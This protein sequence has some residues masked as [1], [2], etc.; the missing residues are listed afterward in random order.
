MWSNIP[1][2]SLISRAPF[3][4]IQPS[5]DH[6]LT[7]HACTNQRQSTH[8]RMN[9]G[10]KPTQ[11]LEEGLGFRQGNMGF[12]IR[13]ALSSL[14]DRGVGSRWANPLGPADFSAPGGGSSPKSET[15]A[16]GPVSQ[17][18]GFYCPNISFTLI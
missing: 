8:W 16:G 7:I 12:Y 14:E 3:S 2:C 10:K 15:Q 18:K 6:P 17:A 1:S 9:S 5:Y 13:G 4:S 11:E